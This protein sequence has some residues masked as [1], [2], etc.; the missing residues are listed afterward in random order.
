M[1]MNEAES[2]DKNEKLKIIALSDDMDS[3]AFVLYDSF[4]GKRT[5]PV[6]NMN[7]VRESVNKIT[8]EPGALCTAE[9]FDR[10]KINKVLS[11]N[12]EGHS[13]YCYINVIDTEYTAENQ[14]I[15]DLKISVSN[16]HD[17]IE[18]A[19]ALGLVDCFIY[20]KVKDDIYDP[21]IELV[22][23]DAD[24]LGISTIESYRLGDA[25]NLLKSYLERMSKNG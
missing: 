3:L 21:R 19:V 20:H 22:F 25:P 11:H 1:K 6:P 12:S 10:F 15:Y 24:E 2:K 4:V 8:W 9:I 16:D 5:G 7:E 18:T 13:K 23:R 14:K 17:F